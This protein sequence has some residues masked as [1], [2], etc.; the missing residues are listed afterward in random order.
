MDSEERIIEIRRHIFSHAIEL[1]EAII[2][3]LREEMD[4]LDT[5]PNN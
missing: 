5:M 1:H 2:T 4:H 3:S